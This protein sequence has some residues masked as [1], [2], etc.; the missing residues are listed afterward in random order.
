MN[1]TLSRLRDGQL[2]GATR[3]A[4][5]EGL[6]EFPREVFALADTL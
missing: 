6:T 2:R 5:R 1:D 4:L 3:L